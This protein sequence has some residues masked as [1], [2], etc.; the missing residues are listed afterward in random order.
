MDNEIIIEKVKS[1]V[2]DFVI[3]YNVCPFAKKVFVQNRIQYSVSFSEKPEQVLQELLFEIQLLDRMGSE[4][5]DT[6]LFILPKAF[7]DF[8]DYL[9]FIHISEGVL[10]TLG[11]EG[12]F[13]IATF[14]PDYQFEG[15]QANHAENFTNRSPYPII[16]L[17]REDSVEQAIEHY[18]NPEDIPEHNIA[19]MNELGTNALQALFLSF[20]K[21]KE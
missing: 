5:L 8:G 1:W 14:H 18:P 16:H 11:F 15:T 2:N 3:H 17:L 7:S 19:K 20:Q 13:Q 4:K 9:D 12:I 6:T 10:A 21:G